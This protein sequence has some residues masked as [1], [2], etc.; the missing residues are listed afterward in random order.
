MIAEGHDG[1]IQASLLRFFYSAAKEGLVAEVDTVEHSD[2]YGG[3][4][5]GRGAGEL[6]Q[7]GVD[8]YPNET[9]TKG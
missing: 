2:G 4:D 9:P 7:Q 3:V 8:L 6:F 1:G 5:V